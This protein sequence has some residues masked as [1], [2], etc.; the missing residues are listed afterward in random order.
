MG[1]SIALPFLDAMVPAQTPLRKTAANPK[2]RLACIEMVHG[3]A[4]ST[5]EGAR[6]HY[7]SP[8]TPGPDF[9][10]SFALEPLADLRRYLT[11]I[12]GTDARQADPFVPSESGADHF[13][14]SAVFLT[15][16]H[17]KQTTGPDIANGVSIDQLYAQRAV[18]DARLPSIQLCVENIGLVESCGFDYSCIYSETI[19]WASATKPLPM[20]VNPRVVFEKLFRDAGADASRSVLEGLATDKAKLKSELGASDR[21]RLDQH[22]EEIRAIERRIEAI[23]RHNAHVIHRDLPAAPLGVP[24]SWEEHVKLMFDLQAL[25]FAADVTR[26]SAFKMSRDTSNRI[27][28]QSGVTMPFHTLSHHCEDPILIAEFAKINRYH[29]GLVADFL[30]KLRDTPDGDGSLLDHS[31]VLYGSPMGDSNTH[32]H[33]R[34]PM[35]LAGHAS[36]QL[37][38]NLHQVCAEGTPQAN[39]LLTM[40]HR[41]GVDVASVGDST[42]EI[43][44]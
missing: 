9:D 3:A 28:P 22:L 32:N 14:S 44:I 25:A 43:S 2:S 42:G 40:M 10:F 17:A 11:I 38:G 30:R 36:G 39:A 8:A 1:A 23:E 37:A 21:T 26:V 7:W 6:K 24:D 12:S 20:M 34:L 18:H 35:F 19:S 41:L 16:A 31:L 13:R 5:D 15:A 33:K 29:V 27:F 4:G